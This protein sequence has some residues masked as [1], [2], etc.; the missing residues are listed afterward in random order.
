VTTSLLPLEVAAVVQRVTAVRVATLAVNV[1]V[2]AYLV[3]QL[4]A[5]QRVEGPAHAG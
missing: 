5:R 2:V 4:R 1:A 3:W